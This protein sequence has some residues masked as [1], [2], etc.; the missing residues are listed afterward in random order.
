MRYLVYGTGEIAKEFVLKAQTADND[1]LIIGVLDRVR[2]EGDFYGIP[3]LSWND[4]SKGDAERLIL[5]CDRKNIQEI[6][7]RIVYRCINRELE[8]FDDCGRSLTEL[9]RLDF[10]WKKRQECIYKD[11]KILERMIYEY[12]VISF[13]IFDTLI[14]RL[15][16]EAED[17]FDIVS[18]VI[19]KKYELDIPD[20]KKKRRTAELDSKEGTVENIYEILNDSFFHDSSISKIVMETEITCDESLFVIRDSIVELF[21]LA[22]KLNR[23]VFFIADSY[24]PKRL[25]CEFLERLDIRGYED[26]LIS[27]D[28][29][30]TKACG[31]YGFLKKRIGKR[32]CL[33][34]GDDYYSDY[35][36][37]IRYGIDA[38]KIESAYELLRISS[39]NKLLVH[40]ESEGDRFY[41]GSLIARIFNDPFSLCIQKGMVDVKDIKSLVSLTIIPIVMVY[42]QELNNLLFNKT[43]NNVLFG[44]RDGWL[45]YRIMSDTILKEY[46]YNVKPIYLLISRR[47]GWRASIL[48]E[49]DLNE[50]ISFYSSESKH[51][52]KTVEIVLSDTLN[53]NLIEKENDELENLLKFKQ[54]DIFR[55]SYEKNSL[56][57][58][59]LINNGIQGS[60]L[61]CDLNSQGT[62]QRCLLRI[63]EQ[64]DGFYLQWR[65]GSLDRQLTHYSVFEE[66]S[67][68]S[69]YNEFLES[70]IS[71]DKPSVKDINSNLCFEFFDEDRSKEDLKCLNK[72]HDEVIGIMRLLFEKYNGR[73][74]ITK[75][76]AESLLLTIKNVSLSEE[77]DFV[78]KQYL[79]NDIGDEKYSLIW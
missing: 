12:D 49:D 64:V 38:F 7:Y 5:A 21:E 29:K 40:A 41:I 36:S 25:I 33:H 11:K 6:Y 44:A 24:Y 18:R 1:V 60:V 14:M 4:V 10:H 20:L 62:I 70:V 67:L 19:E 77:V 9:F 53:C 50:F 55:L 78:N 27:C 73:L 43:Y 72:S 13:D 61:F 66:N 79:K 68:I 48:N 37:P 45:F 32:K 63:L 46:Y 52:W 75:N 26:V 56:Y 57:R 15:T 28:Y 3:I 42:L 69:F 76:L 31:L 2:L 74:E 39:I 58:K 17:V 35:I 59:Y 34:I 51:F 71:S 47:A 30:T 23:T 16:L 8:V 22:K 54:K 65:R